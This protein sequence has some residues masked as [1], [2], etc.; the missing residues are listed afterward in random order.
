[1]STLFFIGRNADGNYAM[2]LV[3]QNSEEA[4]MLFTELAYIIGQLDAEATRRTDAEKP[5]E[6]IS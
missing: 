2:Q 4:K 1:M 5:A 6:Q 3:A